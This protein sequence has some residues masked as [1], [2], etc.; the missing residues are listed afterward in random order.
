MPGVGCCRQCKC[1]CNRYEILDCLLK[2]VQNLVLPPLAILRVS[3]FVYKKWASFFHSSKQ[4]FRVEFRCPCANL[5]Q[6]K[7]YKKC[8]SSFDSHKNPP[9]KKRSSWQPNNYPL[10]DHRHIVCLNRSCN[11]E[12]QVKCMESG[13]DLYLRFLGKIVISG[14][15]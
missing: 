11:I 6:S 5:W 14:R 4:H 3:I 1:V 8:E 15:A 13:E 2:T 10:L 7:S 12:N 9:R